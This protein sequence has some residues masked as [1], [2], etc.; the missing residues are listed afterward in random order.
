MAMSSPEIAL[1]HMIELREIGVRFSVDDFGT[2]YSNLAQL[3]R[4]PFDVLKIDRR[5]VK[6]IDSG[7]GEQA[8]AMV[9]TVIA[10]ARSLGFQTVAEGVETAEQLEMLREAGCDIIQ[11]FL[12]AKPM[13][14]G[15]FIAWLDKDRAAEVA[16]ATSVRAA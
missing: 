2:G 7:E 12:F 16:A 10:M 5:F 6:R 9:N 8:M 4:M 13:P 15:D 14:D 1:A 11:G 3:S